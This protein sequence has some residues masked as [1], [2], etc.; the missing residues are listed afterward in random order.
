M[1]ATNQPTN[2]PTN[3]LEYIDA[4]RG[5]T[6]L[7]VVYSH[8]ITWSYD[9]PFNISS[10]T[11][12]SFFILFRMP[13][14]FFVSGFVLYKATQVWNLK[15]SF[16]FILKKFKVQIISTLIFLGLFC[17]LFD[18]QINSSITHIGKAGYWFT[19]SLFEYYIAYILIDKVF[20]KI[21]NKWLYD[22]IILSIGIFIFFITFK[23]QDTYQLLNINPSIFNALGFPMFKYFIFFLFGVIIKRHFEE[24]K[25]T[26]NNP[27]KIGVLIIVF[28][29][30]VLM[31]L[32][33][34]SFP[35]FL[36]NLP[37]LIFAGFA[38]I[39][40]TFSFFYKY[41]NCF[42]KERRIG[43]VLQ[44]IGRRTLDIYLLHY[45]FLPRNLK[46][47][48]EWFTEN[49]NPTLEFFVS[50]ALAAM[51]IALCLVVSSIIRISPLLANWLFGVKN[52]SC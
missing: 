39:I 2:Q 17:F 18:L 49:I 29:I 13:L 44:Y 38:G 9:S 3:R 48:G 42:T 33:L 20:Y 46:M 27:Q 45:F 4:M 50:I 36:L 19:I 41:Q 23:P 28:F 7:L 34:G 16:A 21:K 12:N 5:F 35:S 22:I 31:Y 25:N 40:I 37:F 8:I 30:L 10:N 43:R 24:F 32:K 51:V 11:F 6:M 26:I 1:S 47:V 15:N 14:F 52:K